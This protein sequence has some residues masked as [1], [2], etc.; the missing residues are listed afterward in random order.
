M[1]A[2]ALLRLVELAD[3]RVWLSI[4]MAVLVLWLMGT[5]ILAHPDYLPYFNA[6]AGDT[7]ENVL[8]DSDLDWGQ[9]M[10]R[11]GAR[12]R[13][14]GAEWVMFTPFVASDLQKEHGFPLVDRKSTRLNSSH[15]IP[16]R[17]PSSA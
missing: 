3:R 13:A 2:A 9:D 7:P 12:L 11:L 6:L 10:N 15:E 4:A 5:S 16:S 17:M 8:V 14:A 1:T